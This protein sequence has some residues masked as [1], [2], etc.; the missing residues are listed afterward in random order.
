[1]SSERDTTP[2]RCLT[3]WWWGLRD[4]GSIPEVNRQCHRFPPSASCDPDG[5]TV[6][7][8]PWTNQHDYCGEHRA[9]G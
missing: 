2:P 5:N 9:Y 1:M 4:S 3:C 8:W 7:H 6:T